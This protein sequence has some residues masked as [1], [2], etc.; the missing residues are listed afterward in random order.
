MLCLWVDVPCECIN[1]W[2]ET[3]K[4]RG[5]YVPPGARALS[6]CDPGQVGDWFLGPSH[7]IALASKLLHSLYEQHFAINKP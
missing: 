2:E 4:G 5:K 7:K 6:H 3:S 1:E